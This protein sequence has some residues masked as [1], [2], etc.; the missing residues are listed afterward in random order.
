MNQL[1]IQI[2]RKEKE[3]STETCYD[4]SGSR[5]PQY[6]SAGWADLYTRP[7]VACIDIG[8]TVTGEYYPVSSR[9]MQIKASANALDQVLRPRIAEK[10]RVRFL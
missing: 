3:V 8:K 10:Q 7:S 6:Y 5:N 9:R 4:H 2:H 1:M